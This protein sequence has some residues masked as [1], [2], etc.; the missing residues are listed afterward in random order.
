MKIKQDLSNTWLGDRDDTIYKIEDLDVSNR[1]D[2]LYEIEMANTKLNTVRRRL[3]CHPES[4]A[5]DLTDKT[6]ESTNVRT[7]SRKT[8][9]TIC[10]ACDT[11][12]LRYGHRAN[13]QRAARQRINRQRAVRLQRQ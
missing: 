13:K 9:P 10:H 5:G 1:D 12:L 2:T 4:Y 7:S 8:S 6:K 11:P 3:F